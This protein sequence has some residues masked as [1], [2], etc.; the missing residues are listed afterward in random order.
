M[1]DQQCQDG[2]SIVRLLPPWP[3][4]WLALASALTA[5]HKPVRTLCSQH[6]TSTPCITC[7]VNITGWWCLC[8]TA[9]TYKSMHK[10]HGAD[11]TNMGCPHTAPSPFTAAHSLPATMFQHAAS[12]K[13]ACTGNPAGPG[14]TALLRIKHTFA[15]ACY[16]AALLDTETSFC[17]SMLYSCFG[18]A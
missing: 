16:P 15:A 13:T 8:G 12:S 18:S 10:L 7:N 5:W 2:T 9:R 4:Q 1:Q 11:H 6:H 17:S 14:Y 3:D